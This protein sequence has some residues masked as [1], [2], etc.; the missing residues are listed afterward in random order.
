[1]F[2]GLNFRYF[3]TDVAD[4]VQVTGTHNWS[5]AIDEIEV[6]DEQTPDRY[7]CVLLWYMLA[8]NS[9][10]EVST[11]SVDWNYSGS[12]GNVHEQSLKEIWNGD[13]IR[14]IRRNQLNGIWNDP[15]VCD[16]CVVWVSVGDMWEYL[17][18][19][20]EFLG[21]ENVARTVLRSKDLENRSTIFSAMEARKVRC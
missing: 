21:D 10:G 7:P 4:E 20:K 6:T 13:R 15:D 3:E 17:K 2:C 5:G 11:C 9:N 12:V 8:V 16:E 19:R 1:M 14:E 18:T